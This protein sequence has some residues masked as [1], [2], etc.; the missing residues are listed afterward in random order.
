MIRPLDPAGLRAYVWEL[1]PRVLVLSVRARGARFGWALPSWAFEEPLRCLLRLAPV[2][3]ALAPST[4]RRGLGR[5]GIGV[6]FGGDDPASRGWWE[7]L[8]GL[9]SEEHRDLL[10]LP[11]DT[12]LLDI[13]TRD[14]RIVVREIR[15]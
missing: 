13:D 12:P 6:P 7:T 8:D 9:F 15:L 3:A 11:P 14:V 2:L 4:V 5:L 10:A 1:R